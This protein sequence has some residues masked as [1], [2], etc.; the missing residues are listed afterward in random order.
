MY[1]LPLHYYAT[2]YQPI[3][4]TLILNKTPCDNITAFIT[5]IPKILEVSIFFLFF[6]LLFSIFDF[7]QLIIII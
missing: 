5:I 3:D 4:E 2:R 6:Y 7:I 1:D